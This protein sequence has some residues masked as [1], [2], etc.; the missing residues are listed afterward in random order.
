MGPDTF[1]EIK[2]AKLKQN[3]I[4]PLFYLAPF[5]LNLP[6]IDAHGKSRRSR[7]NFSSKSLEVDVVNAVLGFLGSGFL[8]SEK[9][10]QSN[11][12]RLQAFLH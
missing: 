3:F 5:P 1:C 7:G 2:T 12:T 10:Y 9:N 6:K 11:S 8:G 4:Q